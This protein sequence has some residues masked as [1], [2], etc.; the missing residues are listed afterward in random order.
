MPAD[1]AL[2][3]TLNCFAIAAVRANATGFMTPMPRTGAGQMSLLISFICHVWCPRP[4]VVPAL[5]T[6]LTHSVWWS[7]QYAQPLNDAARNRFAMS[8][9]FASFSH[10]PW[11]NTPSSSIAVPARSI[12][13][14]FS[15]LSV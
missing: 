15:S 8:W 5:S 7:R 3:I 1:G 6:M 13:I 9:F 2:A 10:E 14:T 12:V 11:A 4:S